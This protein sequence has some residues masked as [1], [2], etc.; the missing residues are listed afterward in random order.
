M[1]ASIKAKALHSQITRVYNFDGPGFS[2]AFYDE[3]EMAHILP[4]IKMYLPRAA[5]IGR[6]FEH[7][8][9]QI[10]IEGYG[11]GLIQ[12]S[13]FRWQVKNDGFVIA[14]AFDAHS[15]EQIAYIDKILLS[16]K[17]RFKMD[18]VKI[19]ALFIIFIMVFSAVATFIA[20]VL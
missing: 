9:E 17:R 19:A 8:E 11:T 18:A 12:H 14:D 2:A 4:K 1:Y 10:I 7:R 20:Y 16:K 6:L 13:S 15:N 5:I 3:N